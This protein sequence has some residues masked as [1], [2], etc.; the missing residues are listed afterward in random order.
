MLTA[1]LVVVAGWYM[2]GAIFTT[3]LNIDSHAKGEL[4]PMDWVL[5][6]AIVAPMAP[7]ILLF[8]A[9]CIVWQRVRRLKFV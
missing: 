1:L 2:V 7:A 5:S 3:Y 6:Y 9:A 8:A 4:T